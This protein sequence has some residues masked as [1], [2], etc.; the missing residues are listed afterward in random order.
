MNIV[1]SVYDKIKKH[2]LPISQT[3]HADLKKIRDITYKSE[4]EL[5]NKLNKYL[6]K[7]YHPHTRFY[8]NQIST[9]SHKHGDEKLNQLPK[10]RYTK[11][12]GF[13]KIYSFVALRTYGGTGDGV[14]K[15]Q[16]EVQAVISV[17]SSSCLHEGC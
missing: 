10:V 14:L 2:G 3:P 1:E 6:Q 4:A 13:I 8:A 17:V 11:T 16:E 9:S 7:Y 15:N 12:Y 5:V